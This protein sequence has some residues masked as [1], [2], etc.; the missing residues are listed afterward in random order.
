MHFAAYNGYVEVMKLLVEN[1][2]NHKLLTFEGKTP[3]DL[4]LAQEQYEA[5]DYLSS[6]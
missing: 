5:A 3:H 1:G 6:L 4:A 2:A